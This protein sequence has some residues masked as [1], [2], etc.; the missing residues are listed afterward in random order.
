MSN[1]SNSPLNAT[2][3]AEQYIGR[4]HRAFALS[5]IVALAG[6][7]A[8][9]SHPKT[10]DLN[11]APSMAT[12]GSVQVRDGVAPVASTSVYGFGYYIWQQLN[13]WQKDGSK[14]YG[15]QIYDFQSYI[16][17]SC[18]E[19][20]KADLKK[21]SGSGEL[22]SRTRQVTEI[23]GYSFQEARVIAEGSSAWTVLLDMQVVETLN[24]T[25]VK[26]TYVRYPLRIVRFEV[27]RERNPFQLG[28][29][30]FGN[31][32]PERIDPHDSA[33]KSL[34][35]GFQLSPS[36][37]PRVSDVRVPTTTAPEQAPVLSPGMSPEL[38][39]SSAEKQ[40]PAPSADEFGPAVQPR[41][42]P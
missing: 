37:L 18:Q 33:V 30:C 34:R 14:D 16:T 6:I 38:S 5:L 10:L 9:W 39:N 25:E 3:R 4:L 20:L 15:T 1:S 24:G 28:L 42:A 29:D 13:R 21:R 40:T 7:Y 31:N 35:K 2:A 8:A 41:A 27:D 32:A 26:N 22:R 36:T 17:P 23:P 12:G 19:Q 11:F